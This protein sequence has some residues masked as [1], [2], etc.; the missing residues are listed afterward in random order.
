[1]YDV[2]GYIPIDKTARQLLIAGA[3]AS[4]S[5][6]P[7][8]GRRLAPVRWLHAGDNRLRRRISPLFTN[9][10]KGALVQHLPGD[11]F[12]PVR[13]IVAPFKLLGPAIFIGGGAGLHAV[14]PADRFVRRRPLPLRRSQV[15]AAN[16]VILRAAAKRYQDD[17]CRHKPHD[18][19]LRTTFHSRTRID[20]Y[21]RR[22]AATAQ[23]HCPFI[24]NN[25]AEIGGTLGQ[26]LYF[27]KTS[28]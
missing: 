16:L 13:R 4:H 5:A 27:S 2:I 12:L 15:R 21:N 10:A 24:V 14:T 3:P 8:V 25:K 26:D 20:R 7:I 11:F 18:K 22:V 9:R 6:E 28:I 19:S 23:R 1:M 17:K